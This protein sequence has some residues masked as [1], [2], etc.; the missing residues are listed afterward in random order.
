MINLARIGE[1]GDFGH[2]IFPKRAADAAILQLHQR[3]FGVPFQPTDH[4]GSS[5]VGIDV[6][7]AHV[8][9]DHTETKAV[10]LT[11]Q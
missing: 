10:L 9:H 7:R 3:R 8:V 2:K 5:D 11:K 1:S 6:E 4:C